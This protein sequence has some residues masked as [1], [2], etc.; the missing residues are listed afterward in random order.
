MSD[1]IRNCRLKMHRAMDHRD[2]INARIE[3]YASGD[4]YKVLLQSHSE[5]EH[6]SIR[7]PDP[8]ISVLVGELIYQCRSTLDHLFFE[9]VKRNQRGI[10]LP[11]RWEHDAA[12]P[13]HLKRP[14]GVP[15]SPV[16]FA[17]F[18]SK[19]KAWISDRAFE[20]IEQLQPYNSGSP[21][22]QLRALQKFSNVDKHRYLHTAIGTVE[23]T[24]VAVSASGQLT[25]IGFPV[26]DGAELNQASL[27]P[28][29]VDVPMHM[30]RMLTPKIVLED[31]TVV[32]NVR[33]QIFEFEQL[34]NQLPSTIAWRIIP[35][36]EYLYDHP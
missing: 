6:V 33:F 5:R 9:L 8:E 23:V 3:A 11:A 26:K 35:I 24:D 4:A 27:P 12:F 10:D 36:F 25:S 7:E 14:D 20:L 31:E 28:E 1:V 16:P 29:W 19:S 22:T 30:K 13:L 32:D 21:Q 18:G 2:A 34:V 15:S 17:K